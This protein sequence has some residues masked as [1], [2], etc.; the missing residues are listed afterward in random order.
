[1]LNNGNKNNCPFTDEI[2]SYIYDEIVVSKCEAFE[3]H[4][5]ECTVCTD[6][7]AA[8]SEA[9]FAMFEWRREEF[10]D[11]PTPEI[12]IP[13]ETKTNVVS[14]T[15]AAGWLDGLR[16]F[17]AQVNFPI[18]AAA[19]LVIVALGVGFVSLRYLGGDDQ[20]IT[21]TAPTVVPV[22]QD[23]PEQK[24]VENS[25]Q[26]ENEVAAA[27]TP[28]ARET[29]NDVRPVKAAVRRQAVN[30]ANMVADRSK[31]QRPG[32]TPANAPVLNNFEENSDNSLRLADLFAEIDS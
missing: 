29:S 18:A 4:L 20:T 15:Q 32:T 26:K 22:P 25:E 2:V 5:A 10:A 7:F 13:Y 19:A 1:M 23:A 6:E 28:R 16:G 8:V 14:E 27:N 31:D 11:L 24:A 12:V 9:R 17:I 30:K 3:N 21:S